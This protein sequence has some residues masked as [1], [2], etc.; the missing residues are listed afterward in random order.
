MADRTASPRL[1][2]GSL[3]FSDGVDSNRVPTIQSELNP[4]GLK[5]TQLAWLTNGTVRGGGVLQRT[6]WQ[7]LLTNIGDGWWQGGYIYEPKSGNPYLVCSIGGKIYSVLLES[8]YTVRNLSTEFGLSNPFNAERAFFCQGEEFLVIQAGDYFTATPPSQPLFWDGT[9]LRRSAGIGGGELPAGTCMDYYMGR[10]WFAQGRTYG[11]GDIVGSQSSGTVAYGYRD[12]ILK[13]TE[14]P[15]ILGGDNFSLGANAGNIRALAHTATI[16]TTLGQGQLFIFTRTSVHSLTVPVTRDDWIKVDTDAGPSQRIVQ[17]RYGA[18][19]DTSVVQINGDLFYQSMEP[20]IRS[21][22]LAIRYYQQWGN[23]QLSSNLERIMRFVDRSLLDYASGIEFNNRLLQTSMPVE[24]A[25]GVVHRAIVPMDFDPISSWDAESSPAW[26][27]H[28]EGLDIL[29]LFQGDFGGRQRAFCTVVSR[30]TG[31]LDLWE[32]TDYERRENG[33][34]RVEWAIETA[35]YNFGKQFDMKQLESGELWIDKLFGT[36]DFNVQ[37][38]PDNDP[39]WYDWHKFQLCAARN[40]TEAG[41]SSYPTQNY[42]ES[43]RA[44]VAFPR[45]PHSCASNAQ[46]PID[47]GYQF[48]LRITIKGWCRVRAIFLHAKPL[49]KQPFEGMVCQSLITY[50]EVA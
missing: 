3:D 18:T 50:G 29:Q 49:D 48:Q 22:V 25:R 21:L 10:L 33:D 28:Y 45:P 2:D 20:G 16:D 39:C 43:Y 4:N 44:N 34:N 31:T 36:V 8:P 26:E 23:K 24:V 11:A 32:I 46:R 13:V 40:A 14:N 5:R 38:R 7:P 37:F 42:R 15:L 41:D 12:S 1:T 9:T 6:G 17:M 35:A 47:R 19:S 27:G 30:D